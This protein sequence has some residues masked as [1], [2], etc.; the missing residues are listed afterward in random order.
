MTAVFGWAIFVAGLLLAST[1]A[2]LPTVALYAR[3]SGRPKPSGL[4]IGVLILVGGVALYFLIPL[5]VFAVF[6]SR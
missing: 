5:A 4:A 6:G 1:V 2:V 3:V